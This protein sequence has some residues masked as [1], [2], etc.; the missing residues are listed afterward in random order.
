MMLRSKFL[1]NFTLSLPME[2]VYFL[3]SG[4]IILFVRVKLLSKLLKA[5]I[6]EM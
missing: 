6:K 4:A 1:E 5:V 3:L 2:K